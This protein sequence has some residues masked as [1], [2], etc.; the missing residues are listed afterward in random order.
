MDSWIERSINLFIVSIA[1]V[2]AALLVP[3]MVLVGFKA[4]AAYDCWVEKDPSNFS[5]YYT[6]GGSHRVKLEDLRSQ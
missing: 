4:Y 3:A 2:F 5:C 6:R 1:L